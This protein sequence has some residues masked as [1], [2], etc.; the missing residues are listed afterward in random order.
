MRASSIRQRSGSRRAAQASTAGA[1]RL[2]STGGNGNPAAP[3]AFVSAVQLQGIS[4]LTVGPASPGSVSWMTSR[5]RWVVMDRLFQ[6]GSSAQ[7]PAEPRVNFAQPV[8]GAYPEFRNGP[9]REEE[10]L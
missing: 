4:C 5:S 8:D 9:G 7:F 1:T 3:Q 2:A 6:V 10:S